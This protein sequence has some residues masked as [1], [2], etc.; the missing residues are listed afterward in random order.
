M[1]S[2]R[3]EEMTLS[4]SLSLA[5]VHDQ[6]G[7]INSEE[8]IA[9]AAGIAYLHAIHK[10]Q[11][12]YI[13]GAS[14]VRMTIEATDGDGAT[15]ELHFDDDSADGTP[16]AKT[17]PIIPV[18]PLNLNLFVMNWNKICAHN[19]TRKNQEGGPKTST[20]ERKYERTMRISL[21]GSTRDFDCRFP[22]HV[23]LIGRLSE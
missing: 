19:P 23:S 5:S 9:H 1:T 12:Y 4:M 10:C 7:N 17:N 22:G 11:E 14:N 13:W 6:I 2:S 3:C 15:I 21:E 8:A 20:V 16:D 18:E